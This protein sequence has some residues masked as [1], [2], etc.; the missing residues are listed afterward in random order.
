MAP[1]AP[2]VIIG[3]GDDVITGSE[4]T[5]G[6]V[7][8]TIELPADAKEGDVVTVNG[9]AQPALTKEDIEAGQVMVK[10]DAPA[11][12]QELT[13]EATI[14]DAAGNQ[15]AP[16]R[17]TATVDTIVPGDTNGDGK[18]DTGPTVTITEDANDDGYISAAE[19]NG[20]VDVVI[21]APKG[22]Q[23]GD[24][25]TVTAPNGAS[26][27]YTVTQDIL[28]YGL[29]VSFPASD[30]PEGEQ[31][32]VT[33]TVTDGRIP[34]E[35]LVKGQDSAT[36]DTMV[37]PPVLTA[38]Q[39]G[40]VTV[41]P[42]TD[43]EDVKS[44][45]INYQDETGAIRQTV[46]TKDDSNN[47]TLSG[48]KSGVE[49]NPTT[50]VVT[51]DENSIL[52]G[53]RV[54]AVATD[55]LDN[56]ST[57]V[58][59]VAGVD[60]QYPGDSNGDGEPDRAGAPV[61]MIKD[62]GDDLINASELNQD[63]TV[64][65]TITLP[66]DSGYEV[67]DIM[68]I[69]KPD[70]SQ[71]QVR[72]T[73]EHINN[74]VTTTFTPVDGEV[75]TVTAEVT[76][77]E[78]PAKKSLPG[79]DST[80]VDITAPEAPTV[81]F[82]EDAGPDNGLLSLDEFLAGNQDGNNEVSVIITVPAGVEIDDKLAI[83]NPDG[84]VEEVQITQDI[85]DNGL[86]RDYPIS[87]FP[88]GISRSVLAR[89]IDAA[90]NPSKLASDAL[91]NMIAPP[92]ITVDLQDNIDATDPAANSASISGN[93]TIVSGRGIPGTTVSVK[94]E[95]GTELATAEVNA[96][97]EYT[98]TLQTPIAEGGRI[99]VTTVNHQVFA[100]VTG[101]VTDAPEGTEVTLTIQEYDENKQ[102]IG[103]EIEKTV[104]IDA[105][106]N[107]ST[108][109]DVTNLK[110]TERTGDPAQDMH[111]IG[112]VAK[113]SNIGGTSTA[114]DLESEK[115]ADAGFIIND[116]VIQNAFDATGLNNDMTLVYGPSETKMKDGSF[117]NYNSGY[118]I[119]KDTSYTDA[120]L[121]T[122]Y[123]DT[124]IINNSLNILGNDANAPNDGGDPNNFGSVD[125]DRNKVTVDTGKGD[126]L[127][128]VR[129]INL[130]V[131]ARVYMGEGND[132][133][134]TTSNDIAAQGIVYMESGNDTVEIAN[135]VYGKVYTGSGSD[136]VIINENLGNSGLIDLGSGNRPVDYQSEYQ[137][138]SGLSL[139][140][141]DNT[142]LA[143][144]INRL[145][146]GGNVIG[147]VIS[148]AGRD[149]INISGNVTALGNLLSSRN[150]SIRTGAGDDEVNV[151]GR[152]LSGARIT[153]DEGNDTV[154][155][156]SMENQSL[157]DG[158]ADD[159]II[160]VNEFVSYSTVWAGSGNDTIN[161]G[162]NISV[163]SQVLSGAGDD[164]LNIGGDIVNSRVDM[165]DGVDII[166]FTGNGKNISFS[167]I[168]NT[169]MIDMSGN[170]ANDMLEDVRVSELGAN[171]NPLSGVYIYGDQGDRVNIG[172]QLT[173]NGQNETL[174][175]NASWSIVG[176][177]Q[178][179]DPTKYNPE[180]GENNAMITYNIWK[181]DGRNGVAEVYIHENITVI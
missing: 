30:F 11:E 96:N 144:D 170:S 171:K 149:I 158:G 27:N 127:F 26:R 25:I 86:M 136:T 99:Q 111:T 89:V 162:G 90:G 119:S 109:V 28:D 147:E 152:M 128:S 18:Q 50:G 169:E 94:N 100:S 112:V 161:I 2:T 159:D 125:A 115:A 67:G 33:A 92:T 118:T 177:K 57:P 137:D 70:G 134:R 176:T 13:V 172:Y 65:V 8:V 77:A 166:K 164:I 123:N 35:E 14:T 76:D 84:T 133:F 55:N 173:P 153:T 178:G 110:N 146:V 43:E 79:E 78:D 141:D 88:Y 180:L 16:G 38:H 150:A 108:T 48:D 63:G 107:Y 1:S 160:T 60:N 81:R 32:S 69:T 44:V 155:V 80:T 91:T 83:T 132:T 36:K 51:I 179:F 163:N 21:K 139:G 15:G 97:G 54:S 75:N 156:R 167:N 148:G 114:S 4:I 145:T 49:V 61:V 131:D 68:T 113:V 64:T 56:E 24:T 124:L 157:I 93:G 52:D 121:F 22:T 102:P 85:L 5:D 58:Q 117:P 3:D 37:N 101:K 71:E 29:N 165:G 103:P 34:A 7:D 41:T 151:A 95:N 87:D 31:K 72:L 104:T 126:D 142:D 175:D 62:G 135:D 174:T 140:N 6:K 168:F 74:G 47:W 10:V 20:P 17:D 53:S 46:A 42:P 181:Y 45:I 116:P 59:L 9:T 40:G 98:V 120:L 106:G 19:L 82:V 23:V 39:K 12:G 143:T 122:D 154:T 105:D 130:Y 138:G 129:Q 66:F 73:Q